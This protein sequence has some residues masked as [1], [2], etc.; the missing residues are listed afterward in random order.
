MLEAN[1]VRLEARIRELES[2]AQNI[3]LYQPYDESGSNSV[4]PHSPQSSPAFSAIS[5]RGASNRM[6]FGQIPSP[7]L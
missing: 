1:I 5:P 7:H 3:T 4:D 6:R 2:P